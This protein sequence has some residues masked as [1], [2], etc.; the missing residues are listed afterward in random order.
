MVDPLPVTPEARNA[1]AEIFRWFNPGVQGAGDGALGGYCDDGEIA[2]ILARF[3]RDTF[4]RAAQAERPVAG[5]RAALRE[6]MCRTY[7][8]DR[9]C[10]LKSESVAEIY[11]I[12]SDAIAAL[13]SIPGDGWLPIESAPK[14]GTIIILTTGSATGTGRWRQIAS[15]D[16]LNDFDDGCGMRA[17]FAPIYGWHSVS[18][19]SLNKTPPTHWMPLPPAPSTPERTGDE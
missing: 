17:Q 1:A 10:A 9:G 19:K 6:I 3:E 2:Q 4:A 7:S 5:L 15:R 13:S 16:T 11:D 18:D 14:D 8:T 12:A